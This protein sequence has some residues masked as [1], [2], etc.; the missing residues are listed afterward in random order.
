MIAVF[1]ILYLIIFL[2]YVISAICIVFHVV[3]YSL[4]KSVMALTLGIFLSVF[5]SL[6]FLNITLFLS[7]KWDQIFSNLML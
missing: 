5:G 2:V 3:K 1:G 6:L 4:Y 7:L